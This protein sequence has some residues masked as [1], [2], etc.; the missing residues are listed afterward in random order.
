MPAALKS[1]FLRKFEN[2]LSVVGRDGTV[3]KVGEQPGPAN[4]AAAPT[5]APEGGGI[6]MAGNLH[7]A[8]AD[9]LFGT[10]VTPQLYRGGASHDTRDA[11]GGSPSP[12]RTVKTRPT[13]AQLHSFAQEE[14]LRFGLAHS[15]SALGACASSSS[16]PNAQPGSSTSISA[17]PS[18]SCPLLQARTSDST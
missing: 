4:A 3:N 13:P 14:S 11:L 18:S 5:P 9:A 16:S 10:G 1:D 6:S 15:G 12:R 2:R 17:S 8:L 7:P